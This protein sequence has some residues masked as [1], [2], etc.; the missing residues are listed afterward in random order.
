MKQNKT[1]N[2]YENCKSI[3]LKEYTMWL[4][5]LNEHCIDWVI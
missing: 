2:K 3:A 5:N 1:L 4:W